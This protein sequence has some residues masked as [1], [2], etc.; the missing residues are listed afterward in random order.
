[1]LCDTNDEMIRRFTSM[2][3]N[4]EGDRLSFPGS[5]SR[6][7]RVVFR[8]QE[9]HQLVYL[10][11]L[12]AHLTYEEIHFHGACLRITASD[13]WNP[14]EEAVVLKSMEQFRRGFGENR[15]L[16]SAPGM[17]FRHDEFVQSVSCLLHP[18]LVGWDA[19]YVPT[20]AWGGLKYFVAV[21]HDGFVDIE[22]KSSETEMYDG[23]EELLE[24]H[25]WI[26]P[27]MK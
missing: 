9:P 26:K 13:I 15:P 27:L 23:A 8:M 24:R 11:R 16:E 2:E 12:L 20:W 14:L 7:I 19:Y 5:D 21:S 1:M 17:H 6:R 22:V 18:M 10:A 3:L 4:C 25:A